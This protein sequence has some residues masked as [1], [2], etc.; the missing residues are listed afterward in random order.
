MLI[1]T[2]CGPSLQEHNKGNVIE[3]DEMGGTFSSYRR[4]EKHVTKFEL[5]NANGRHYLGYLDI[6]IIEILVYFDGIGCED[7]HCIHREKR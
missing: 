7:M 3:E 4:Y 6:H 1:S 5:K 2:I